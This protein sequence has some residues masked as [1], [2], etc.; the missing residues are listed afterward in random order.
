MAR[1]ARTTASLR[2]FGDDLDPAALTG[3]LGRE[4][5]SS[6]IKGQTLVGKNTG[7]TRVAKTG[8]WLLR[9]EDR[10]PGDLDGQI[11]ELF[12]SL[13]G[14]LSIWEGLA[15]QYKPDLF[16]GMFLDRGN[17]ML[18]IS[19]ETF[20]L[21]ASRGVGVMLDIYGSADADD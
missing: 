2:F 18:D 15:T 11:R 16:I 6:A 1:V 10:K 19:A 3:T 8:K 21:M 7:I 12:G 17:E 5:T 4:P 9:V 14:D 13:T 20:S